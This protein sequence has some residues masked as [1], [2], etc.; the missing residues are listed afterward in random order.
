[1]LFSAYLVS[2]ERHLQARVP[3][4]M[5]MRQ[6]DGFDLQRPPYKNGDGETMP[7]LWSEET[8]RGEEEEGQ[9]NVA[10]EGGGG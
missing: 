5:R 6:K 4:S 2:I 9:P 3:A 7:A 10:G 1:M 8:T